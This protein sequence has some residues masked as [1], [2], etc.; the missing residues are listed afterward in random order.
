MSGGEGSQGGVE[1]RCVGKHNDIAR[2]EFYGSCEVDG[3]KFGKNEEDGTL[4]EA[5]AGQRPI[6]VVLREGWEARLA[7]LSD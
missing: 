7:H 6:Q 5:N 2:F 3:L 4:R 1:E